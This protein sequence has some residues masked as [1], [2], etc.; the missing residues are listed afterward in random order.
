MNN[1]NLKP[2]DNKNT[3]DGNRLTRSRTQENPELKSI[4]EDRN[5]ASAFLQSRKTPRS[6]TERR[7]FDFTPEVT[8]EASNANT[9]LGAIPRTKNVKNLTVNTNQTENGSANWQN[10]SIGFTINPSNEADNN[11]Q[12]GTFASPL[13]R[14]SPQDNRNN[15]EILNETINN[16][17][18]NDISLLEIEGITEQPSLIGNLDGEN[19]EGN[20]TL[21][22]VSP[23]KKMTDQQIQIQPLRLPLKYVAN[24]VPEF[25][26]KN[27]SV[28]E[29][30]EKVKH[31]KNI[32]TPV[33]EP[34]LIPILKIKLKGEVYKALINSPINNVNDFIQAIKSLFP[35]TENIHSLYGKLTELTQK[36]GETVLSYGNR[37][38]ELVIQIKDL[39]RME[40]GINQQII[41]DFDRTIKNDAVKSFKNGLK[42]EI[43][44]ELKQKDDLNVLIQEAIDIESRLKK[45]NML[46]GGDSAS[47]LCSLE[48][49]D[50]NP[51]TYTCQICKELNHEAL[52]CNNAACVYCKNKDHISYNCKFAR[53]KIELICKYCNT[54]GH[55]IDACR[56]NR[57][58]GNYCQYCQV[59]GHTVTQCPF[60]IEYET[61][62]K[63]KGSGHDPNTCTRFPKITELCEICNSRYHTAENCPT[64]MC[65]LCNKLGHT[66]KHCPLTKNNR[67]QLI[68]CTN[69]NEE[70]HD[71]EECEGARVFQTRTHPIKYQN[72]NQLGHSAGSYYELRNPQRRSNDLYGDNHNFNH[73]NSNFQRKYNYNGNFNG[74]NHFRNNNGNGNFNSNNYSRNNNSNR[75]N[76]RHTNEPRKFCD[77]CR[78]PNHTIKECRKLKAIELRAQ[79]RDICSYCEEPGHLI[80]ACRKLKSLENSAGK[81]CNLCKSTNH[82]TEECHRGQNHQQHRQGNE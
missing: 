20:L 50:A 81:I 6:P 4:V 55:S 18:K 64:P 67:L 31:A 53:N 25:D 29:Y 52:F 12:T 37:L 61:C 16:S 13:I 49:Y 56:M 1:K 69:C 35:S 78:T 33:D 79:K 70:G 60:I 23:R 14:I 19:S 15:T 42:Q 46:R 41:Q 30:V 68:M 73:N 76:P 24:L 62:W 9:N 45:Q 48:K 58:K 3:T 77:Y 40:T 8:A 26:G 63:C 22:C 57:S 82:T 47:V 11:K 51:V 21:T 10:K 28:T 54:Q 34:N 74:N 65:P 43:R 59:M 75:D 38:Q 44:I 66:I 2:T 39:K 27:I 5:Y 71:A 32:I 72:R 17:C 7:T 80:D 36:P